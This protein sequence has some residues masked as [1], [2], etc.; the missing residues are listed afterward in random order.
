[1]VKSDEKKTLK[2]FSDDGVV[3]Y[4]QNLNFEKMDTA[5]YTGKNDEVC[6]IVL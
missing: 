4:R 3:K 6:S 5:F 1:M 2:L